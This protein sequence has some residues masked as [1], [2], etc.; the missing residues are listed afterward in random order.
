[1]QKQKVIKNNHVLDVKIRFLSFDLFKKVFKSSSFHCMIGGGM[2]HCV[3]QTVYIVNCEHHHRI[4]YQKLRLKLKDF[5]KFYSQVNLSHDQ[6]TSIPTGVLL[7][8]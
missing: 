4:I 3:L 5:V 8:N 1:M 7:Q 2:L 6:S